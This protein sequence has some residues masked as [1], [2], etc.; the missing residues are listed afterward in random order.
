MVSVTM[1][2]IN[3]AKKFGQYEASTVQFRRKLTVNGKRH[4]FLIINYGAYNAMG[5]I[6]TERNGIAILNETARSVVL[7]G[8]APQSMGWYYG[9]GQDTASEA[10]TRHRAAELFVMPSR[11]FRKFILAHPRYRGHLS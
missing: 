6:G 11:D 7:D 5:L 9:F 1:S 3:A 4:T 10:K 8:E 2:S